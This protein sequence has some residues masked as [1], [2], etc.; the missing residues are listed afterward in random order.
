MRRDSTGPERERMVFAIDLT[1]ADGLFSAGG[2]GIQ[3]RDLV[4]VTE[5]PVTTTQT[6]FGL[7]GAALGLGERARGF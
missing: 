3:H 4:L 6:V 1:T 2:F 7:I 5:S